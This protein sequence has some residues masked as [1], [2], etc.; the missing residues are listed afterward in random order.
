M[1][2][3]TALYLFVF[4]LGAFVAYIFLNDDNDQDNDFYNHSPNL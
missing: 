4:L 1:I 2:F 3:Q